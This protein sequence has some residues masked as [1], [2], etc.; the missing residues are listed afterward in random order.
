MIKVIMDKSPKVSEAED[1][2]ER[3]KVATRFTTEGVEVPTVAL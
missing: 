3:R 1:Q 2:A